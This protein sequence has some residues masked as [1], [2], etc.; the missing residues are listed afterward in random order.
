MT[1]QILIESADDLRAMLKSAQATDRVGIDLEG[2]GLFR[3]RTRMCTMQL[4]FGDTLAVVDTLA[5]DPLPTEELSA[6]LGEGGPLKILHDVSFD[7]RLLRSH[8]L[9]LANVFD[10]AL[11]ARFLGEPSTGL[12]ALLKA[13]CGVE[14]SKELQQHDWGERPLP[15]AMLHYL[16]QDVAHLFR[17]HDY[18][19]RRVEEQGIAPELAEEL[20]Y[21]LRQAA[22]EP[23][24]R[25]SPW[26][27]VKAAAHISPLEQAVL[28]ELAELREKI[29]QE[30]DVPPFRILHD[31]QLLTLA[32]KRPMNA[33]ALKRGPA[34]LPSAAQ[35]LAPQVL[36]AIA[37]GKKAGRP[38]VDET[39]KFNRS[40]PS[41]EER[42]LRRRTEKALS[43]FRKRAAEAR[44]VDPQVILPGHA[45]SDVASLRPADLG[46][47][48]TVDGLGQCRVERYGTAILAA[49]A[50]SE[51]GE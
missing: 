8:G 37:R 13:H 23:P 48:T 25:K 9:P 40:A 30:R 7:A 47:L 31:R 14:L 39:E 50:E 1:Q 42:A 51:R 45:L 46:Q 20:A 3:Y 34:R 2:D 32:Q 41:P 36:D 24:V 26:L 38:P 21:T 10:T 27:R 11:S 16:Y 35:S 6:L 5:I 17:L 49:L 28:R 12:A 19:S 18:L 33:A 4:S 22:A 43:A 15:D 44:G 29:A